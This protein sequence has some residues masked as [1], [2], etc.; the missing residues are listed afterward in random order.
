MPYPNIVWLLVDSIRTYPTDADVRG[1]LPYMEAFGNEAVEFT[2]CVTTAPSTIMSV[3]AMMTGLPAYFLARNYD[4]FRFDNRHYHSLSNVLKR[5]GYAS[6]AFL[7]G[8]ETRLKFKNMLDPVPQALWPSHLKHGLK[9]SNQDLNELLREVLKTDVPRPAFMFFHFNPQ[10]RNESKELI[11]DPDISQR[12]ADAHASLIRAGFTRDNTI[13][14]LCSDHGFPDPAK[15]MT[16]EWEAKSRLS[17][18]LVLTDDNV[19]IPMY[20]QAPGCESRRIDRPMSSLDLFPTLLDLARIPDT[21]SIKASIDGESLAV[22][23]RGE[24]PPSQAR[25]YFRC[26]ARL[27]LQTGRA[28]AIRS[29]RHKYIRFHD[30]HR[31]PVGVAASPEGEVLIDLEVDSDEERNILLTTPRPA[32]TD[33]ILARF[34]DEF[35]ASEARAVEFQVRYLLASQP[36][37]Q[38][39]GGGETGDPRIL[40]MFEPDTAG[41]AEIGTRAARRTYPGGRFHLLT[42]DAGADSSGDSMRHIYETGRAGKLEAPSLGG[43]RFDLLMA[44]VQDPESEVARQLIRLSESFRATRRLV[45][46]CN[47]NVLR[48]NRYWTYRLRSLAERLRLAAREPSLLLSNLRTGLRVVRRQVLKRLGRWD[49]W[50]PPPS[51]KPENGT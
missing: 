30:E 18:D 14:I 40:L 17:H 31:L 38:L 8:Q 26:D 49:R 50:T 35:Q 7:R 13:T 44:F 10:T 4:D 37:K 25:R 32:G 42:S 28:T 46:D 29:Q 43:E 12:V 6:Y 2:H 3:T 20:I 36:D 27:M 21:E 47:F 39:A 15:G 23:V 16:S 11:V 19:L 24:Q 45:V 1:R 9:W 51:Q 5:H 33:E 22:V 41:F 48:S 34:R